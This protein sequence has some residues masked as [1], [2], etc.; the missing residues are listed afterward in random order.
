MLMLPFCA[1]QSVLITVA[2]MMLSSF[3]IESINRACISMCCKSIILSYSINRSWANHFVSIWKVHQ[4]SVS[5]SAQIWSQ[6]S[7]H[8]IN[9][10]IQPLIIHTF[11]EQLALQSST[12]LIKFIFN[13]CCCQ[14]HLFRLLKVLWL[15]WHKRLTQL[16]KQTKLT[17]Q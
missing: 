8:F 16:Q 3:E 17:G 1:Q 5:W 15:C 10:L 4:M 14:N 7:T 2:S 12:P 11:S 9:I 6:R 13:A